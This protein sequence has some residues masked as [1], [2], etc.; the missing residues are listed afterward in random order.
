MKTIFILLL[1]LAVYRLHAQNNGLYFK[2]I[3][4]NYILVP[5]NPAISVSNNFTIEYW[6]KP[7]KIESYAIIL[8]QGKCSNSSFSYDTYFQPDTTLYFGFN[9]DG[10]CSHTNIYNCE[11]KLIIG[12]CLHVTITYSNA[13]VKFYFNGILQPG[14][15]DTGYYCGDLFNS[16]E[17]LRIASYMNVNDIMVTWYDG[18]LDELRIWNRVL[19]DA[20]I[21]NYQDTLLGYETGL[22]LY[23]KFDSP[24]QGQGAVIT[25][26][27]TYTGS[28]VNGVTYSD[29][30]SSPYSVNSCFDYNGISD[31]FLN[32]KNISIS[33]NPTKDKLTIKGKN[34]KR[35][36]VYNL[37]G[38]NIIKFIPQQNS[39][40]I[41]LSGFQVG[42]Y[43][44]KIFD[45][46]KVSVYK[47]VKN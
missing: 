37:L 7:S 34:F 1:F 35:I 40:E 32:S 11:T 10:Q 13:G 45:G 19:S 42:V 5:D 2:Q 12:A 3:D 30:A 18:M 9:C 4:H 17:Q 24:I 21:L 26:Y 25:N 43:F 44:I 36:E 28:A 31:N 8:Q 6:I 38:D 16:S 41:D 14:H 33:P 20:E 39:S 22:S 46:E 15:Y 47:I 27:A 23:F 29:N